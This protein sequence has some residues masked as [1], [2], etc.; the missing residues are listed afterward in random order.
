MGIVEGGQA[1]QQSGRT[2]D[3][4][5]DETNEAA[6]RESLEQ[7]SGREKEIDKQRKQDARDGTAEDAS[8]TV[9]Q[10]K[11]FAPDQPGKKAEQRMK[12]KFREF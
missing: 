10:V 3:E 12:N 2:D 9:E 5:A 6:F 11:K 4:A 7:K 1:L 8:D